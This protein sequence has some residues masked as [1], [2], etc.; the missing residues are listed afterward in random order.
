MDVNIKYSFEAL[1]K[2]R[3][4]EPPFPTGTTQECAVA[5][6]DV[7]LIRLANTVVWFHSSNLVEQV[8][9]TVLLDGSVL[10][11]QLL[12]K[13]MNLRFHLTLENAYK[14]YRKTAQCSG[15]AVFCYIIYW[16]IF[17]IAFYDMETFPHNWPI[18]KCCGMNHSTIKI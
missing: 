10:L 17:S 18:V 16:M 5:C 11:Y 1:K 7:G 3:R 2:T 14:V 13:C 12:R 9:N 15:F 6:I 8:T 4:R